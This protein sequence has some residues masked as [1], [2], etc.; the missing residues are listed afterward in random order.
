EMKELFHLV[1]LA[2]RQGATDPKKA[3]AIKEVLDK[4]KEEIE[5]IIQRQSK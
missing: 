2:G 3:A 1:A 5:G 4:A